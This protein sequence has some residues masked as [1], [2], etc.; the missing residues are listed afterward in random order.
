MPQDHAHAARRPRGVLPP[1]PSG[2]TTTTTT[3]R[4]SS[5]VHTE[6][7]SSL[8]ADDNA[9]DAPFLEESRR[10]RDENIRG[11]LHQLPSSPKQLLRRLEQQRQHI[12]L[13]QN[14]N[15]ALK[16]REVE[17][18]S[19]TVF[20]Q[21]RINATQ[22]QV[23]HIK[24]QVLLQLSN[25]ITEAEYNR[26]EGLPE[27]QRD[28]VDTIKLGI[29]RQLNSLRTSQQAAMQRAAELSTTVAELREENA[30]LK[31]RLAAFESQGESE[32]ERAEKR[33]RQ[34]ASQQARV[35]EL[36][37]LVSALEAKS[38]SMYVDQE[39]Y[40]SAKLTAQVKTDEVARLAV[41]LE[42]AEMDTQRYRANAECSE[43]KLDIL[44][45]EYYELKL[46]YGQ[47]VLKLESALRASE[48]KLKTLGDL[49][50]ESE[51]F[52]SNLAA[53][54]NGELALG[55]SETA[56]AGSEA[57]AGGARTSAY[58]T[59]LAL[60]RSRRLAHSLVVTKRCL[61]L[62]NKVSSLEHEMAFKQNQI[63]RLQVALDGAREALNNINSPYV[64][65]ERAMDEL[66][67]TNEALK[68]KVDLLEHEKKELQ[69]KLKDYGAN[70]RVLT[71]HRKELLHIKKL[72]RRLG[73]REGFVFPST[74]DFDGSEGDD[75]AAPRHQQSAS[76]SSRSR[77]GRLSTPLPVAARA[78]PQ[79]EAD[80]ATAGGST[81]PPSNDTPPSFASLQ[82]IEIQS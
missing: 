53:S 45:A 26:I 43:Q 12:Q 1:S 71:Q 79:M 72:L 9:H 57:G 31:V 62:E 35:A 49:E 56:V 44:K 18:S 74:V 64:L 29:Y 6:A 73:M 27:P 28:L 13:L 11:M 4:S 23:D 34:L 47:R 58:E 78:S 5:P 7:S 14:E 76:A 82:P 33:N 20:L 65:V 41:R 75:S 69:T 70:M 40:L 39:Q 51:L 15:T 24:A 36:E 38:K 3:T 16:S 25:P 63:S 8:A 54:A 81:R 30:A 2:H 37:G 61:Y 46:D 60:P 21:D 42:E 80:T 32:K 17:V 59:W 52:I 48:E 67:T 22:N 77:E 10:Y 66:T 50:M 19:L 55:G 68:R